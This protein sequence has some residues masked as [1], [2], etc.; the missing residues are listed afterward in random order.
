MSVCNTAF[1]DKLS[2][3][4][5]EAAKYVLGTMTGEQSRNMFYEGAC[6]GGEENHFK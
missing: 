6:A 3:I 2:G 4:S 1:V 5:L